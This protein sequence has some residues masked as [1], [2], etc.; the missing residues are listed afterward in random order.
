MSSLAAE[1]LQSRASAPSPNTPAKSFTPGKPS[2]STSGPT[3]KH[4][5]AAKYPPMAANFVESPYPSGSGHP[6]KNSMT[7]TLNLEPVHT[8]S[9]SVP[10]K[11]QSK[12]HK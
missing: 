7:N 9:L 2:S 6:M 4:M 12:D 8:P 10:G 3:A 5:P 1:L 11:S